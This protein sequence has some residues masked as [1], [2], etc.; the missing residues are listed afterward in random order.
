MQCPHC[1]KE[2]PSDSEFCLKCGKSTR[3]K[4]ASQVSMKVLVIA[5]AVTAVLAIAAS[6][7]VTKWRKT[8]T[9]GEAPQP[10]ASQSSELAKVQP[11]PV[12]NPTPPVVQ[13]PPALSNEELFKLASP[14]V[15][16]IEVFNESGERSGTGSGFVATDDGAI[17]TNYHVIRGAS[18]ANIHLQD[19]STTTVKGVL[20][21]DPHRDVAVIK[22][23]NLAAKSLSLA[24]S[25]KVQIGDKVI[26]IGSPLALQNTISD[27]L[28]SGIRNGVIQTSTPISPGS[29][30]GPFF[31]THG[32]V[33]GIAVAGIT[34]GQNLN[35]VVPINWA[36]NY[37]RSSEVTSLADLL[38]QNTV[39]QQ[40]LASTVSVPAGQSR[41]WSIV[42]DRNRMSNPELRFLFIFRWSRRQYSSV[43]AQSKCDSLRFRPD[44]EWNGSCATWGRCL[45]VG[46]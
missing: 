7:F 13:A 11:L 44:N 16:L 32:E 19:G 35:F 29:S 34:I 23:N 2:I 37:L 10:A 17:I 6:L 15:V 46:A 43:G 21:F 39:E 45:S 28:V 5:I 20:G 3:V 40:L 18:S 8:T 36:K 22:A 31:N 14:S 1:S 26:A 42:V 4:E 25:E 24:D 33:V 12:N 27:G 38:K 41:M 9:T 30:G